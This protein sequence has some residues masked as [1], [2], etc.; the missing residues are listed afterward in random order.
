MT[1]QRRGFVLVPIMLALAL[2]LAPPAGADTYTDQVVARFDGQTHVV[3]DSEAR[4][5]LQNPA[6]LN[7]QILSASWSWSAAPQLWVAAVAP[8]QTG[9]T[10]PDA[11]H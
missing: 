7:Q 3:A 5:P 1:A 11:I 8:G 4:P 2:L 6:Q 10:T 9:V